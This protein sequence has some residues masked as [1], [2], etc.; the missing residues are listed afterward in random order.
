[1]L[2]LPPS[3]GKA[4]GGSGTM[5]EPSEGAF[6]VPLAAHRMRVASALQRAGGGDERLLGV[7][8]PNLDRAQTANRMLVGA[9]T[10]PAWRRYTG[11]VWDALDPRSIGAVTRRRIVVVSALLGLARADD[12]VPDYRLKMSSSLEPMGKLSSWW[13]DD[14]SAALLAAAKRGRPRRPVVDLLPLEH[15]AA[16]DDAALSEVETLRVDIRTLDGRA[17]GHGAK[18]AKGTLARALLTDGLDALD[19]WTHPEYHLDVHPL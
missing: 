1:M 18:A 5:W 19:T 13:R 9:S 8:G 6:G 16:L 3:E 2:L 14:L 12:P 17:G 4:V 7:R 11:V 10:L 15:R